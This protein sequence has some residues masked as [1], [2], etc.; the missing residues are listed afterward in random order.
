M[1]T[2]NQP[3]TLGE[4]LEKKLKVLL[5]GKDY[6]VRSHKNKWATTIFLSPKKNSRT[7]LRNAEWS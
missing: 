2:T 4:L 6:N 1:T 7:L 3:L 5:D